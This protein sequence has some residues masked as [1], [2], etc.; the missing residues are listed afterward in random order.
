[1]LGLLDGLLY[2]S[3]GVIA[4]DHAQRPV[5]EAVEEAE[6]TAEDAD[7]EEIAEREAAAA[8]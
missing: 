8:T 3:L 5:Q 2:R 4:R 7:P 1:L 6:Q